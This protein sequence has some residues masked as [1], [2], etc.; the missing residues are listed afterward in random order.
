MRWHLLDLNEDFKTSGTMFSEDKRLKWGCL[1]I[2]Q[3]TTLGQMPTH[4]ISTCHTNCQHGGG[5]MMILV[6]FAGTG[7]GHLAVVE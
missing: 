2:I 1:A 6:Y 7:P 4:H 3:N 5:G